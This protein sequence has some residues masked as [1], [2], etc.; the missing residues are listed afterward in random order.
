MQ[1]LCEELPLRI[2]GTA[3]FVPLAVESVQVM[4]VK[5]KYAE[6]EEDIKPDYKNN[7][8]IVGKNFTKR[9]RFLFHIRRGFFRRW[10]RRGFRL[11]QNV[12]SENQDKS[13]P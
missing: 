8:L 6:F 4:M 7:T 2:S 9:F 12:A 11:S 13:K 1:H 10:L 5:Q 3:E